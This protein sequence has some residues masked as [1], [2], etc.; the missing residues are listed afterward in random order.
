MSSVPCSSS[1]RFLYWLLSFIDVDTLLALGVECLLPRH[2]GT[3]I[4]LMKPDLLF[5]LEKLV[6][7]MDERRV[8]TLARQHGIHQKRDDGRITKTFGV[9][10][11]RADEGTLSRLLVEATI[12]L[13]PDG[14]IPPV[15]SVIPLVLLRWIQM[16]SH[17]KSSRSLQLKRR[18]GRRKNL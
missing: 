12:M 8:E 9:F 14:R 10:L 15:F 16:V 5:L 11:R 13:P 18:G 17:S 6:S 3:S 4:R 1:I 2:G 7:L